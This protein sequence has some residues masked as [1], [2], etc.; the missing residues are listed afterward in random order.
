MC[1]EIL[2]T[3]AQGVRPAGS[4]GE[5]YCLCLGLCSGSQRQPWALLHTLRMRTHEPRTEQHSPTEQNSSRTDSQIGP[6]IILTNTH[7]NTHTHSHKYTLPALSPDAHLTHTFVSYRS[8]RPCLQTIQDKHVP[9]T[10]REAVTIR[11][12]LHFNC[13]VSQWHK[14]NL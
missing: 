1:H 7:T 11:R 8:Q 5:M 6:L 4:D 13:I 10:H 2:R 12:E 14:P 9:D 3:V